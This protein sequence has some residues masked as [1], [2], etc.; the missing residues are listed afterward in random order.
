MSMVVETARRI[1]DRYPS[2]NAP[3]AQ[4]IDRQDPVVWGSSSHGPLSAG[5]LEKYERDGFLTFENLFSERELRAYQDELRRLATDRNV[6]TREETVTEPDS[7][8]V[9]SV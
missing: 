1:A 3:H 5:H 7:G 6:K 9:R 2:R 4:I 8:E